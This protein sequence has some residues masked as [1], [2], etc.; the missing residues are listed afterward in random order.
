M[1][2]R[3]LQCIST[4]VDNQQQSQNQDVSLLSYI[5]SVG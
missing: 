5:K 2:K 1:Q 4:F 3:E